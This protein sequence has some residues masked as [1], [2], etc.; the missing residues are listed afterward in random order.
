MCVAGQPFIM[1]CLGSASEGPGPQRIESANNLNILVMLVHMACVHDLRPLLDSL[2]M[3]SFQ[4][5]S[6]RSRGLHTSFSQQ[7]FPASAPL[8]ILTFAVFSTSVLC[9]IRPTEAHELQYD[10]YV[11]GRFWCRGVP[12]S[13]RSS[14]WRNHKK[15]RETIEKIRTSSSVYSIL[16]GSLYIYRKSLEAS[17]SLPIFP[18]ILVWG[19]SFLCLIPLLPLRFASPAPPATHLTHHS[20]HTP[21]ITHHSSHTPLI[22]HHSSHTTHHTHHSS[23]TTHHTP[24]ISHHSSH[25]PLIS[26]HSS[27]TPL[28]THDSSHTT[29]ATLSHCKS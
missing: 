29:P 22:T 28:I 9:S 11:A 26:H 3:K 10:A 6:V 7:V 20:S 1:R 16:C 24:L 27:H 2:G 14:W 4:T 13:W 17:F 19:S 25:T 21:L 8:F 12:S 15:P 23:H 5:A 18:H